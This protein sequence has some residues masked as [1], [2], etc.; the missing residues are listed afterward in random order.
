MFAST[1]LV[2]SE[3]ENPRERYNR[4]QI[5]RSGLHKYIVHWS[6]VFSDNSMQQAFV[7]HLIEEQQSNL[8]QFLL[9]IENYEKMNL[10][11]DKKLKKFFELTENFLLKNSTHEIKIPN[12]EKLNFLSTVQNQ[13]N[14]KENWILKPQENHFKS[15]QISILKKLELDSFPRFIR[16]ESLRKIFSQRITDEKLFSTKNNFKF[17]FTDEDFLTKVVTDV[18]IDF[19]KNLKK[20]NL[21]WKLI[22]S[23]ILT[24]SNTFKLKLN[25]FLDVS[26]FKDVQIH[27]YESI[28]PFDLEKCILAL[29][30]SNQVEKYDPLFDSFKQISYLNSIDLQKE[31]SDDLIS[32]ERGNSIFEII[33]KFSNSQKLRKCNVCITSFIDKDGNWIRILKPILPD[34][35]ENPEDWKKLYSKLK[36]SKK[37]EEFYL[38]PLFMKI[39]FTK[40]SNFE[41]QY[42]IISF[43]QKKIFFF[44]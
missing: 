3:S 25:P 24:N 16:K 18:D 41:T 10:E 37:K 4:G 22:Y 44:F 27:K 29:N 35:L 8:I 5:K 40:I 23:N 6:S 42:S 26:F 31:Y 20:D 19:M 38:C 32:N 21:E 13:L 7:E 43:I 28:L 14:D 36:D 2:T 17:F 11:I 12:E 9:E 30:S 15:F 1:A 39:Q 34:H 33:L